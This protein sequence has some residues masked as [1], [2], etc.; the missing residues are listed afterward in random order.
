MDSRPLRIFLAGP[1]PGRDRSHDWRVRVFK[2]PN[3]LEVAGYFLDLQ[4]P[5]V[6]AQCEV[7]GPTYD[8][9]P[10][11]SFER[12]IRF[13]AD[14]GS[15]CDDMVRIARQKMLGNIRKADVGIAYLSSHKCDP[16]LV[17]QI[18]ALTVYSKP[19]LMF[20]SA[21]AQRHHPLWH[22]THSDN[23]R[24]ELGKPR[25]LTIAYFIKDQAKKLALV[26]G[27]DK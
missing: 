23:V 2:E 11:E 27:E 18:V 26:Q 17:H 24:L 22:L 8:Y 10:C 15:S 16:L 7:V 20:F 1:L 6:K 9:L 5:Y 19:I 14:R 12:S 13:T 25:L 4:F 21:Q 3:I